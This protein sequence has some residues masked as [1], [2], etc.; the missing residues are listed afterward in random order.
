MVMAIVE[1]MV[2][3]VVQKGIARVMA[4]IGVPMGKMAPVSVVM[5]APETVVIMA[6][7]TVVEMAPETEVRM[8]IIMG[9]QQVEEAVGD[10]IGMMTTM[11]PIGGLIVDILRVRRRRRHRRRTIMMTIDIDYAG[12]SLL[13]KAKC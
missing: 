12:T 4:P 8:V 6:P 11:V 13:L 2:K 3:V 5:V 7:V 1:A 10:V 9:F